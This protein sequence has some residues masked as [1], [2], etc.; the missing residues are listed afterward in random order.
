M[1]TNLWVNSGT[2]PRACKTNGTELG[3]GQGWLHEGD[4]CS[5]LKS[6][7]IKKGGIQDKGIEGRPGITGKVV[8]RAMKTLAS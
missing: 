7:K 2:G 8:S 5:F 3:G 6:E 1:D 4:L